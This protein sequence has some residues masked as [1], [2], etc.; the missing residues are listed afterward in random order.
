MYKRCRLSRSKECKECI[1]I[2]V[3]AIAARSLVGCKIGIEGAHHVN[4]KE[5]NWY[6]FCERSSWIEMAV[7]CVMI[8]FVCTVQCA[9]SSKAAEE[10]LYSMEN[11]MSVESHSDG[12]AYPALPP[13]LLSRNYIL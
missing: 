10:R 5:R 4:Q 3:T 8:Y 12:N 6:L 1:D 9:D 13:F 7:S 11:I 2:V